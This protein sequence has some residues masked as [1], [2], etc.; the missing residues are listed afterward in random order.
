MKSKPKL[1]LNAFKIT[2]IVV[3]IL[4][5]IILISGL[6]RFYQFKSSFTHL[7]D[8]QITELKSIAIQDLQSRGKNSS[9][10]KIQVMPQVRKTNKDAELITE[11]TFSNDKELQSYLIDLNSKKILVHT[12]TD[13][14]APLN[15]PQ[16]KE[17]LGNKDNRWFHG[18]LIRHEK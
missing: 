4:F 13:F 18:S 2:A 8:Q 12:A 9:D 5:V 10:Y 11:V 7:N 6:I 14:Y 15:F 17:N 3:I 16:N 1:K